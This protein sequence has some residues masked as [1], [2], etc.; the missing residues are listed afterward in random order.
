MKSF[1]KI[2]KNRMAGLMVLMIL[3]VSSQTSFSQQ[4]QLE[5]SKIETDWWSAQWSKEAVKDAPAYVRIKN[6]WKSTDLLN[7]SGALLVGQ[8]ASEWWDAMWELEPVSGAA[9]FFRIKNRTTKTYLHNETG[10]IELGKI[11]P[12][13]WSAMWQ[14][15]P[16]S[17]TSD[18]FRIKNRNTGTYLHN[19]NQKLHQ[20]DS[21]PASAG[22][23]LNYNP[24]AR[25]Y[26]FSVT[27]K[28][29]WLVSFRIYT[30]EGWSEWKDVN[31]GSSD[32]ISH[33]GLVTD[34]NI[35][36][37]DIATWK[38]FSAMP[39]MS[40]TPKN[41]SFTVSGNTFTGIKMN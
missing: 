8:A 13:W 31:M 22:N 40:T 35:Q 12:N 9:G 14:W 23:D 32:S 24:P 20:A 1:R 5:L 6:R 4:V 15:E 28:S 21:E 36:Y 37:K 38:K 30:L 3:L 41:Q 2:A 19:Q 27:N 18:F 10:K 25:T 39:V 34:Y 17:G 11:E 33:K 26:S 29:I 16:V 7:E